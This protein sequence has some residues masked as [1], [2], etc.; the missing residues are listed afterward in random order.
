MFHQLTPVRGGFGLRMMK[1]MGWNEGSALG[2]EGVG[3]LE[4][5]AIDVK[6]NRQGE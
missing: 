3:C 1:K 4:P 5:I 6:V 2:K